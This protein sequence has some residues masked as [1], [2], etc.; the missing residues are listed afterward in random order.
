MMFPQCS[1]G[2]SRI[3][4]YACSD[5][6]TVDPVDALFLTKPDAE[7]QN[8]NMEKHPYVNDAL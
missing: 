7:A 3:Y 5:V 1:T 2:T 4:L 8:L 6:G